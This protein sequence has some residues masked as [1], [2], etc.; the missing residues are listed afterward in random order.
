MPK[1]QAA[2]AFLVDIDVETVRAD[3]VQ[4]FL[5]QETLF[6]EITTDDGLTGTGYSYTIGT[7]GRAVLAMLREHLI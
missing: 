2:T 3:A 5:K 1:I 6:V 4:S 7:G